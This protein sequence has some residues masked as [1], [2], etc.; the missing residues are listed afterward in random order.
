M[1]YFAHAL[2]FLN[3]PYFAAATGIPDWPTVCDRQVR[4]RS[5]H[6]MPFLEDDDPTTV[7]VAGGIIQHLRDDARF[8]ATRAFAETSLELTVLARDAL[9][10]ERGFRPSFLGH[11]LTEVLLDAGLI[12]DQPAALARYYALL[13]EIDP[14]RMEAEVNR[15][16][17]RPT[18][19]LAAMIGGFRQARILSD[20]AEDGKLM[21]RLNQVMGRVG[22]PLLP[23]SFADIL[24]H[25]RHLVTDRQDALLNLPEKNRDYLTHPHLRP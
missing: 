13:D 21:V 16:A 18:T 24:P 1:N 12:A 23:D 19:L 6:A 25:A 15:M 17:P 7:D 14:E 8:H 3:R 4:L 9:A 10:G 5:K 11:L 22:C 2:P 20:Y